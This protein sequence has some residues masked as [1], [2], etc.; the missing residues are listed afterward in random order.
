MTTV[1]MSSAKEAQEEFEGLSSSGSS[2]DE[3][4][5]FEHCQL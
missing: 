2:K 5:R 3:Q 1:R 4:V